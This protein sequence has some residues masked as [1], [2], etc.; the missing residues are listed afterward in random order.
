MIYFSVGF[1]NFEDKASQK[2]FFLVLNCAKFYLFI[3]NV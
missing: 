1:G 3:E 2:L